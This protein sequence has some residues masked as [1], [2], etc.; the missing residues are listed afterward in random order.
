M[1]SPSFGKSTGGTVVCSGSTLSQIDTEES[2]AGLAIQKLNMIRISHVPNQPGAAANIYNALHNINLRG[3]IQAPAKEREASISILF[4]DNVSQE[5]QTSLATLKI[6]MMPSI[7]I[8]AL[9][10]LAVLTLVDP[11]M[12]DRPGYLRD[13]C[14]ALGRAGINIV[15]QASPGITIEVMVGLKDLNVAAQVIATKFNLVNE[16]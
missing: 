3:S 6:D 16:S 15:S 10:T 2:Q 11:L 1:L 4:S 9:E 7:K 13:V 12:D 14:D 8:S 5:V